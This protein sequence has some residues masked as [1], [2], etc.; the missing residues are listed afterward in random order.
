MS[1]DGS[2]RLKDY[3]SSKLLAPYTSKLI[4]NDTVVR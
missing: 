3:K 4:I 2:D 1:K